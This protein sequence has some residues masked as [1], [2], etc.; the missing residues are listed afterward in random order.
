[1][2]TFDPEAQTNIVVDDNRVFGFDAVYYRTSTK[3][4]HALRADPASFEGTALFLDFDLGGGDTTRPVID[5]IERAAFEGEPYLFKVVFAHS[6]NPV[7]QDYAVD[8][9]SRFYTVHRLSARTV[10]VDIL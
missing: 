3:A 1:M 6:A 4:L 5:E 7:G 2:S 10:T 9:L 8:A